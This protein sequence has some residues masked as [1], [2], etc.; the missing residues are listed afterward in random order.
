[1]GQRVLVDHELR[2]EDVRVHRRVL[3]LH[4]LE[5]GNAAKNVKNQ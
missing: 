1:M 5:I 4:A 3:E 2:S